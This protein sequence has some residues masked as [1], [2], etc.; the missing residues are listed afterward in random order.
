MISE[1]ERAEGSDAFEISEKT[2]REG[3]KKERD[4]EH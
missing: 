4:E 3:G 2:M 1:S